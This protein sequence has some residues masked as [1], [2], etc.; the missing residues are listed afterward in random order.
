MWTPQL[1]SKRRSKNFYTVQTR[2]SGEVS[3]KL[4]LW[5]N[6][7]YPFRNAKIVVKNRTSVYCLLTRTFFSKFYM[8]LRKGLYQCKNLQGSLALHF[9]LMRTEG[10][11]WAC[12]HRFTAAQYEGYSLVA[13]V[14]I[15]CQTFSPSYIS[16]ICQDVHIHWEYI[17]V[18]KAQLRV[19]LTNRTQKE[20]LGWIKY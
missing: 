15:S 5:W 1:Q 17:K 9:S 7:K 16:R 8:Y 2:T 10:A 4:L 19:T 13:T 11:S 20:G 12:W 18:V 14:R 6:E 3:A